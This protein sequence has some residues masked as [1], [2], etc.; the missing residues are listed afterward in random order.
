MENN[1]NNNDQN[2][3]PPKFDPAGELKQKL[4]FFVVALVMLAIVKYTM[5]L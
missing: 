5:G 4:L 3:Q 2:S 1:E